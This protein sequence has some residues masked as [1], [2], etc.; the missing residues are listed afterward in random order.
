MEIRSVFLSV[1]LLHEKKDVCMYSFSSF[2]LLHGS[3][4]ARI[5][6]RART[7]R[8]HP[9]CPIDRKARTHGRDPAP[10]DLTPRRTSSLS[11]ALAEPQRYPS[12]PRPPAAE[13]AA[14]RTTP[15]SAARR[16]GA[17]GAA[18]DPGPARLRAH[19]PPLW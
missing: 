7:I 6:A 4:R 8:P 12:S 2:R 10:L 11:Q 15:H 14:D 18:V 5:H 17:W 3:A 16:R 13:P 9:S 19:P 1:S